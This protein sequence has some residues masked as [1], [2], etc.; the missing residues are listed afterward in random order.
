[1]IFLIIGVLP[2]SSRLRAGLTLLYGGGW[3]SVKPFPPVDTHVEVVCLGNLR[4][5]P[6]LSIDIAGR[7]G[8]VG[9]GISFLNM[10][11]PETV[12][13][14]SLIVIIHATAGLTTIAIIIKAHMYCR[15]LIDR[16]FVR[17]WY[18]TDTIV[19][20]HESLIASKFQNGCW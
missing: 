17:V 11:F 15:V 19:H 4:L 10:S 20:S 18:S 2:C 12:T 1:M 6:L 5:Y 13:F 9:I 8:H 7:V 14:F 16:T 3:D